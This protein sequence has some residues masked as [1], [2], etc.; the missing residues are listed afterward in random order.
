MNAAM[1]TVTS[2]TTIAAITAKIVTKTTAI[3]FFI[4][5]VLHQ[6]LQGQLQTQNRAVIDKKN[7]QTKTKMKRNTQRT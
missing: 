1:I 2:T 5:H 4:V 6:E 7:E 3:Q